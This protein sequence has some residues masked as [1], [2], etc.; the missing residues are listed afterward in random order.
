MRWTHQR[1]PTWTCSSSIFSATSFAAV[2]LPAREID[3]Q[4][5]RAVGRNVDAVRVEASDYEARLT[6]DHELG[7]L[8]VAVEVAADDEVLLARVAL[9]LD[10]DPCLLVR[11][12]LAVLRELGSTAEDLRAREKGRCQSC[13]SE[14][15]RPNGAPS[16]RSR[17]RGRWRMRWYSCP[18]RSGR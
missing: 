14:I 16:G 10:L 12:V 5:R 17:G 7:P 6:V 15:A 8:R 1:L 13:E 9:E 3:R 18:C 4:T 11:V 2:S